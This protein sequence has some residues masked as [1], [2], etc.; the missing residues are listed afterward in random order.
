MT[1]GGIIKPLDVFL[2]HRA[3]TGCESAKMCV[4][5]IMASEKGHRWIEELLMEY[6]E[7]KFILLD[8]SFDKTTNTKIIT[9]VTI[10]KFGWKPQ[11]EHQVLKEDLNIYPFEVFCAKDFR[12]GKIIFS[13]NTYNIHHF[14]GSWL[15]KTDKLKLKIIRLI[16]P[17][18]T[19]FIIETKRRLNKT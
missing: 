17:K 12:T 6:N 11:N 4:T 10:N 13:E 15:T 19:Q 2:E 7:R 18:G 8:G 9:Q 14:S 5:G 1:S 16:G 3:F